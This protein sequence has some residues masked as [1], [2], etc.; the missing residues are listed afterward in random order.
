MLACRSRVRTARVGMTRAFSPSSSGSAGGGRLLRSILAPWQ[1]ID[2]H[3]TSPL[4]N[5]FVATYLNAACWPAFAC[6]YCAAPLA[7]SHSAPTA[8]RRR[9]RCFQRSY[10]C[11]ARGDVG[12]GCPVTAC[13]LETRGWGS[14]LGRLRETSVKP[15]ALAA[16]VRNEG[17]LVGLAQAC[18]PSSQVGIAG[19]VSLVSLSRDGLQRPEAVALRVLQHPCVS[20]IAGT[21][22]PPSWGR[23]QREHPAQPLHLEAWTCRCDGHPGGL[24]ER[25]QRHV[26]PRVMAQNLSG[27]AGG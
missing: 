8:S 15:G 18:G 20:L 14:V 12:D 4:S 5:V 13:H 25:L 3:A 6:V 24:D 27:S 2:G 21:G 26:S 9:S 19:V 10:G 7:C 16:S 17:P 23:A 11:A 22:R 1:R